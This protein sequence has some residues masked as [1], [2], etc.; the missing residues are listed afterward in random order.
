MGAPMATR[1]VSLRERS[2]P[3]GALNRATIPRI[4]RLLALAHRWHRLIDSGEIRDQAAIARASGLTRARV[5]Q[6]MNLR[7]LP[8]HQQVMLVHSDSGRDAESGA[9]FPLLTSVLWYDNG[10]AQT[11]RPCP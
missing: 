1:T 11:R 5:T 9:R 3:G 8:P 6:I 7:W 4:V 10:Q 2:G